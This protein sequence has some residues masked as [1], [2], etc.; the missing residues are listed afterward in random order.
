MPAT[1]SSI[2]SALKETWTEERIAEQLYNDNPVLSR[3]KQLKN[4]QMGRV[5]P[6]SHSRGT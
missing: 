3:I 2:Q 4:T 1:P 6:D 5:C